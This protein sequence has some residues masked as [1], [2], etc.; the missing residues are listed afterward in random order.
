MG[1]F[2]DIPVA[3]PGAQAP[4]AP[5]GMF[6]DIGVEAPAQKTAPAAP[7][8]SPER[9]TFARYASDIGHSLEAGAD[10]GVAALLGAPADVL[11]MAQDAY[12][13]GQSKVQ[14][15]P[16]AEIQAE[17]NATAPIPREA[18]N[19]FGGDAIYKGM[20]QQQYEPQ[21]RAGKYARTAAEFGAQAALMPTQAMRSG[22]AALAKGV[23][24]YG[25]LPGVASE[26]AGQATEGT[27]LEP[28]ARVGAGLAGAVAGGRVLAPRTVDQAL[29][30]RVGNMAPADRSAAL[31][32]FDQVTGD[33]QARGI[34]LSNANAF[35]YAT[36]GRSGMS[37]MQRH[38]EAMGGMK[39]FYARQPAAV[40]AA[41]RSEFDR[42][43]P[44]TYAPDQVGPQIGTAARTAVEQSP[45]GRA[46]TQ[47]QR[48]AGPRVTPLQ[49]GEVI[50]PDQRRIFDERYQ[51][52]A[53]AS[54]PLYRAAEQA[55][56]RV[57]VDRM[58]PAERPGQPVVERP[59]YSQPQFL[60]DAPKPLDA[61]P[62]RGSGLA[63]D[64]GQPLS[65]G[66]FIARN[67]GLAPEGD[68]LATDLHKFNVPG[69]GGVVRPTGKGVDD[70]WRE[71]LIEEGYLKPD[72]DGG[73]ARDI[74]SELLR[75]LQNEQRGVPAYPIGTSRGLAPAGGTY[76]QLSD[77]YA[78]A[79]SL[80]EGRMRQDLS[81][82]GVDADALHPAIRDRVV[83]A[84][85]RGEHQNG[86]DAYDAVANSLR[87]PPAPIA[88]PTTVTEDIYAPR[89]GQVNPQGVIDHIDNQLQ[90]AR[91]PVRSALID[92][93]KNLFDPRTGETDL[94]IAG[95][96]GARKA[97][98]AAV[99]DAPREVQAA[100]LDTRNRLDA[101]L[102]VAPE[103][104]A[105]RSTF[106]AYS[107]PLDPFAKDRPLGQIVGQDQKTG[108]FQQPP[109]RAPA[110]IDQGPSAARDLIDTRSMASRAAYEGHLRTRLLDSAT[111]GTDIS[112]D[113]LRG[114]IR[115]N[116]DQLDQFPDVR[117]QLES[118]ATAREGRTVVEQS[119]VGRLARND[120]KT[121]Q[122]VEAL[123]PANPLPNSE[124]EIERTVGQLAA[125]NPWA[126]RQLVRIHAE[127]VFNEATQKNMPGVNQMGGA[128]FAAVLAGNPQQAT[129]L[130]S[131]VRALPNGNVLA[132][133]F[134]RFID[135]L[136]A[137]GKRQNVGSRTAYNAEELRGMSAGRKAEVLAKLAT[138]NVL[139]LSKKVE[140]AMQ[141]WRLGR[142]LDELGRL[143]S[144]PNAAPA[145]RGLLNASERGG[146]IRGPLSRLVAIAASGARDTAPLRLTA[147]PSPQA[148]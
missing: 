76:G 28:Y 64:G 18:L 25:A 52:R 27:A 59:Q 81:Q 26:A 1:M 50:Q 79:K 92:A 13:W 102:S 116:A 72:A 103:Y 43:A 65:L 129:N 22:G 71:R 30:E 138:G 144:D 117:R 132:D 60:P 7:A 140:D 8:S 118:I 106:E 3:T 77:E 34:P 95:L 12:N 24:A 104:E 56:E 123:F 98:N 142:N 135:V 115:Q 20:S 130:A 84:L 137:M 39:D 93:R 54:S 99:E 119:P 41:A 96:N 63:Q 36:Q 86:A 4:R 82:V 16:L 147:Q 113:R 17:A 47:A 69:F 31:S 114:L 6:D 100:L 108:R 83:G 125:A 45:E 88:R 9:S 139:A 97:I 32:R 5:S 121:Q 89:F 112:A 107:R 58:L 91:G 90:N 80:A 109:E 10:R 141:R 38:V 146:D 40:D 48:D 51:A 105:A 73:M 145:F 128:K 2:D 126:A 75:K 122:A 15:R 74:S 37:D 124:R 23:A 120:L 55:P 29:A 66:Q 70:F 85:A 101:A 21:T 87:D 133:G 61:K 19:A 42:I 111:Q 143:F 33:A 44:I 11:G 148:Q 136:E 94:S 46:L 78:N 110:I 49:A 53:D 67:G 14:G 134:G 62:V 127:S 131:A 57:G 35:D 68:V